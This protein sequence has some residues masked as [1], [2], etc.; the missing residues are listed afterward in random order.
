MLARGPLAGT[1]ELPRR[2]VFARPVLEP[3]HGTKFL[4]PDGE[5]SAPNNRV[6]DGVALQARDVAYM[7]A[8]AKRFSSA[9]WWMACWM[10]V[11]REM[12]PSLARPNRLWSMVIMPTLE[13]EAMMES[14]W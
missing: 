12:M 9:S 8:A 13:A 7:P 1:F 3:S 11:S 14:I 5:G 2:H 10:A 6:L 4:H